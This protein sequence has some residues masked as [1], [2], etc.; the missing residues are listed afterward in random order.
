[1]KLARNVGVASQVLDIFVQDATVSTGA[2][3]ANVIG[4]SVSFSWWHEGQ[5]SVSTG[6]ASTAGSM[7]VY[8]TSAWVQVSSSQA[9]GWYQFGAPDGVFAAGGSAK[10]HFYGAPSMAPVPVEIDLNAQ[11]NVTDIQGANAVTT[12]AGVLQAS[13]QALS[14]AVISSVS[15]SVGSALGTT[16]ANLIQIYGTAAVTSGAGILNVSTQSLTLSVSAVNVSSIAGSPVATSGAGILNVSTQAIDKT[17]YGLTAAERATLAGV[18]LTTTQPEGFRTVNAAGSMI[19]LQY[20]ILANL[21]EFSISGT[22]RTV[23]SVTSH[24]GGVM[25]GQ[26]DSSSNPSSLKRTA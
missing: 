8:S 6:T 26:F 11:V 24:T 14:S 7:G 17:G 1:M 22:T 13:T 21:S 9:L 15:G 20:E 3:L 2:G 12:A 10:L 4:S 5:A 18:I 19:Q 23:N 16:A 25:T